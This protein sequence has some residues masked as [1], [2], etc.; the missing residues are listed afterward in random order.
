MLVSR[1]DEKFPREYF[2]EF[3]NYLDMDE[4]EFMEISDSFC[5]P[6]LWKQTSD[7]WKLRHKV[8]HHSED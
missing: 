2:G 7:G 8:Q 4:P 1:Y 6:H 5:S 3:L